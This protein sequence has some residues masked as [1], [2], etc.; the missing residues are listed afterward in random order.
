VRVV[1]PAPWLEPEEGE[2]PRPAARKRALILGAMGAG[3]AALL[4]LTGVLWI[5]SG[6]PD[7]VAPR[8]PVPVPDVNAELAKAAE[9]TRR[10]ALLDEETRRLAKFRESL[11]DD[12]EKLFS[13]RSGLEVYLPPSNLV[14]EYRQL[15]GDV[16]RRLVT[17]ADRAFQEVL[18]RSDEYQK[19]EKFTAAGELWKSMPEV[20]RRTELRS[21]WKEEEGKAERYARAWAL[22]T[23]LDAKADK[24]LGQDDTEI[25]VAILSSAENYPPGCN[26]LYPL[27]W[28]KRED[29]IR[30]IQL[31][32]ESERLARAERAAERE[33]EEEEKERVRLEG[34]RRQRWAALVQ[35]APWVPL[36][37]HDGSDLENWTH[38][39]WV[40]TSLEDVRIPWSVQL[41][42]G[43]AVILGNNPTDQRDIEIGMNGNRWIDWVLEFEVKVEAGTLT[44]KTRTVLRG[45]GTY[46]TRVVE[47]GESPKDFEFPAQAYGSWKKVRIEAQGKKVT[48]I[49]GGEKK[50][51]EET[52]GRQNGGF[53]FVLKPRSAARIQDVRLKLIFDEKREKDESDSEEEG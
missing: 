39:S 29:R 14:A 31:N 9:E 24:Y 12:P 25:S 19:Q 32:A 48:W 4:I 26:R 27:I 21:K 15:L 16:E 37:S 2:A 28:K 10:K 44:L 42:D 41:A 34:V 6:P 17:A 52:S 36:I 23:K 1:K 18:K 49:V 47:D 7:A 11:S 8:P 43:K 35:E 20:V 50:L 46:N 30:N 40:G 53:V 38:R 51:E 5:S 33:R 45:E 13:L 3:T 22:W